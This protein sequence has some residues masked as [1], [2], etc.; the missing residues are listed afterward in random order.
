MIF[1]FANDEFIIN[2]SFDIID[3]NSLKMNFDFFFILTLTIFDLF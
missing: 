3:L 2:N 1:T